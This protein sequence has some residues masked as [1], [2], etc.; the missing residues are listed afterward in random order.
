MGAMKQDPV[1]LDQR[2]PLAHVM[3]PLCLLLVVAQACGGGVSDADDSDA[4]SIR[5]GAE[6]RKAAV[7]TDGDGF[8][9]WLDF[10][11][12]GDAIAD[13]V[14]AGDDDLATPPIDTDADGLP[15]FRDLDSDNDRVPDRA[16][17][18][19]NGQ[20]LD[21][22][23]DGAPDYIDDDDDN[24]TILDAH[25]VLLTDVDTNRDG[26]VDRLDPDTDGDGIPDAIEAG[27]DD[28]ITLPADTDADGLANFR[29]PDSD[30][31]GALDSDED[32]NGNGVVDA[33]NQQPPCESSTLT[34]DTDGDGVPDLVE[35]VAGTDPNDA[36]STIP[37]GD[38]YFVL[39]YQDPAQ[40][41]VLAFSTTLRQADV[42]F[43]V[44]TTGSFGE[45]IAAIQSTI[46]D[47]IIPGVNL[48]IENAAFGVG[49][50]EDFPL[51]PFGLPSDRPFELL[52]PITIDPLAV[53]TAVDALPPA[54]G[55]L[56]TPEAG[57]EALYQWATG[58]GIPEL[59]MSAFA[60]GD[61]GG[62]GFRRNS[63]PIIIQI[64]DAV[65]HPA[66]D[67]LSAS[68]VTRDRDAAVNAL[69]QIGARVIGVRSTE[70]IGTSFDPRDEL[71]ALALATGATVPP[72]SGVCNTGLDGAT[73]LPVM[74]NNRD[75]CP[76][77]FDVRPDGTGT[78]LGAIIVDAIEQ[79]ASFSTLDISAVPV[80]VTVGVHGERLP[81]GTDT[82]DFIQSIVPEPPAPPGSTID[83]DVFRDVQPGSTVN[84]RL[85]ARNDF[86]PHIE[87]PQ[88]FTIDIHI[89]GDTVTV[90]DVRNV[91]VVVP[92]AVPDVVLE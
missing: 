81:S 32:L 82:A 58:H 86:V 10:D 77:V 6:G 60:P 24:D 69:Q 90:L 79:L 38:F 59:G 62:A 37:A 44:D 71:E 50:F 84:F 20:P 43:S 14:E 48:V 36:T 15:D 64:T 21:S 33:C 4:D 54:A 16:T 49:R 75:V 46:G 3:V 92:R 89:L 73:R 78:G 7:N 70:N 53:Q 39:P 41:G 51:Q 27:D 29:D 42:F 34:A 87:R 35:Q 23:S 88:L 5:N 91:Y 11:T 1:E 12:D 52:A 26:A 72:V 61:I 8:P 31:D 17:V 76:L 68:I 47:L 56:D 30:N 25:E 18:D 55:G 83:G 80:G 19:A 2:S 40:D 22:D 13:A 28:P 67:Y 9:D 66:A 74:Q 57:V 45:E 65:S 85:Q 63:L